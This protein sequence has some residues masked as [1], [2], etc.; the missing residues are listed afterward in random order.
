MILKIVHPGHAPK[1]L[2]MVKLFETCPTHK[3]RNR[4]FIIL[5]GTQDI[6]KNIFLSSGKQ[7]LYVA[8]RNTRFSKFGM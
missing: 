8:W 2:Q 4:L 3:K 7:L 1:M 5:N 6:C